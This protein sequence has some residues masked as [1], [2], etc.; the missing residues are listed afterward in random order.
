MSQTEFDLTSV[1]SA[2]SDAL[3]QR[4]CVIHRESTWTYR[5]LA[6]RAERF[7]HLLVS[8]GLGARDVS[9]GPKAS[10]VLAVPELRHS[11]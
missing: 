4:P 1:Y 11:T 9:P 8:L 6:D 2:I 3:P 7:A 10:W 5:D